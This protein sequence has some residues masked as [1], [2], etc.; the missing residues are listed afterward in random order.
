MKK[1]E[2][3]GRRLG[4]GNKME[5]QMKNY[6][7]STHNLSTVVRTSMACGTLVPIYTNVMLNGDS[8]KIN[9]RE[10][11]RTIPTIAPLYGSFKLQ[12]DVF[13]A[14]I[15]LYQGILHNNAVNIGL[16]MNQVIFPTIL[17]KHKINNADRDVKEQN[18]Y[19]FTNS[20]INPSSLLKYL[21]VSGLGQKP[22][23]AVNNEVVREMWGMPILAYYD[24]FKNYYANKQEN[25]AYVIGMKEIEVT[26]P[27]SV[28]SITSTKIPQPYVDPTTGRRISGGNDIYED[29]ASIKN[30][31]LDPAGLKI[32]EQGFLFI[33]GVHIGTNLDR[34]TFDCNISALCVCKCTFSG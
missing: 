25:N 29:S 8:W 7:R 26:S 15:R 22:T 20:Q 9:L 18:G 33:N 21:G 31:T 17:L 34:I 28:N 1:V 27:A 6:E 19:A 14:P 11:V 5:V 12:L 13:T 32:Y 30:G 3:G 2:L 10:M 16:K 4:S 24:I 23:L